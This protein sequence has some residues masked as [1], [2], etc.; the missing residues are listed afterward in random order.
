[1]FSSQ[2]LIAKIQSKRR[3]NGANGSN[4]IVLVFF[5][6]E[7]VHLLMHRDMD[8]RGAHGVSQELGI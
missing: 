4:N 7:A 5:D 3:T 6:A 8:G 2:R 1:V